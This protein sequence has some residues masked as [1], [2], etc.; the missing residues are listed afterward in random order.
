MHHLAARKG[1]NNLVKFLIETGVKV[2]AQ[3]V[4][5]LITPVL[6]MHHLAARKGDNNLAKFLIETGAM[7]DAQNVSMLITMYCLCTI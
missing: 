6:F 4:S 2:D 5:I 3:N 7:V 1:D